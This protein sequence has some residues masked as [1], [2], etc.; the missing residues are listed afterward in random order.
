MSDHETDDE[1]QS[2]IV[3]VWRETVNSKQQASEWRGSIVHVGSGKRLFFRDLNRVK[4]FI[5]AQTGMRSG[6]FRARLKQILENLRRT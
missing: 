1:T 4:E 6:A 2:F 5:E 3:R